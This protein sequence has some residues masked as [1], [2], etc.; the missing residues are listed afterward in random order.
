MSGETISAAIIT[1]ASVICA[2]AFVA[3]VFPP[4]LGSS[5]PV[6]SSTDALSD[7]IKTEVKIIHEEYNSG[8]SEVYI[9]VKSVGTNR[10]FE[11]Q[12]MNS[13]LFFGENGNFLRVPYN[14]T[15]A[16][17]TWTYTLETGDDSTWDI[18]ETLRITV[19]VPLSSG[20]EY[21]VKFI[22]YNGISTDD[23]FT[24]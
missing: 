15:G 16:S 24:V 11:S 19:H 22:S 7:R 3:A 18:G 2:T 9:W 12:I 13:D 10:I 8:D 23:Y 21:F 14:A 6:I 4:I 17:N 5:T 20:S 1:I